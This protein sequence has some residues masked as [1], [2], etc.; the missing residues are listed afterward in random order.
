MNPEAGRGKAGRYIEPLCN[1]LRRRGQDYE[2][3]ETTCGGHATDLAREAVRT[4]CRRLVVVGGDGTVSEVANGVNGWEVEVGIVSVGTGNDFA[5]S[6]GL[7]CGDLYSAVDL[8]LTGRAREIDLGREG[9][10]CFVS[11]LG[12]GFPSLVARE[13]N[14][15]RYMSGSAAFLFGLCRALNRLKP[16]M[17]RIELDDRVLELDCVAVLVQNTPYC[18]G[19]LMIAP[20]ARPDDGFFDVA[21]LRRIGRLDLIMNIPRIYRGR[22]LGHP[23]FAVYRSR[24]VKIESQPALPKMF[25][26]DIYGTTPVD[27]KVLDRRLKVIAPAP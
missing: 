13:T 16:S 14:R 5:R 18:G 22:H 6:L 26:G 24:A 4:G 21:I 8:A 11:V 12:F 10:R 27:A 19:G 15:A 25:D 1:H 7:P 9:D 20:G 23:S 3:F 2:L 17:A